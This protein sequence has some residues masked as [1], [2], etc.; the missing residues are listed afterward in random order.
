VTARPALRGRGRRGG[1]SSSQQVQDLLT[2][3][4]ELSWLRSVAQHLLEP[5]VSA[6]PLTRGEVLDRPA[7]VLAGSR[8]EPPAQGGKR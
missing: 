4:E 1:R 7:A 2:P 5:T 6:R 3:G 8:G